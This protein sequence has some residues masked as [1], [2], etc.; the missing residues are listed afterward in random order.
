MTLMTIIKLT[1]Q[2]F[3]LH[4]HKTEHKNHDIVLFT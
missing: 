2:A 4:S 3:F 1:R